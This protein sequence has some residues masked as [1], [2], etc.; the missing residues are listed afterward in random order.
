MVKLYPVAIRSFISGW[1]SLLLIIGLPVTLQAQVPQVDPPPAY[2]VTAYTQGAAGAGSF[3]YDIATSPGATGY[4]HVYKYLSDFT[5]T[6][7]NGVEYTEGQ[8][9]GSSVFV[10]YSDDVPTGNFYGS[11]SNPTYVKIYAYNGNGGSRIYSSTALTFTIFTLPSVLATQPSGQGTGLVFS[12]ISTSGFSYNFAAA[13]GTTLPDGYLHLR[14]EGSAPA[15]VPI[16]GYEIDVANIQQ[17]ADGTIVEY[18]DNIPSGFV[19][20]AKA[21]TTYHYRIYSYKG[22]GTSRNYN[23]TSPLSGQVTTTTASI[24]ST[25]QPSAI[26]FSSI[27][28]TGFTH[29][30]T[31]A[32][33]PP[34]GY[35]G[36]TRTGA[37]P[38]GVPVDGTSYEV[39]SVLGDGTVSFVG[40]QL[41]G[42][43]SG[44][45]ASTTYH[46]DVFSYDNIGIKAEYYNNRNFASEPV[47]TANVGEIDFDFGTGSP[48]ASVNVDNFSARYSFQIRPTVSG[49]YT[50]ETISDDGVVLFVNGAKVIDKWLQQGVT[51][52]TGVI[53][54]TANTTYDVVL[55][56]FEL[57]SAASVRLNWTPPGGTKELVR[58]MLGPSTNYLT[59]A[60]LQNSVTTTSSLATEPTAQ[61]TALT[62][63]SVTN[64][65]FT[66]S[67][68]AAAGSPAG[69]IAVR[70]SGATA[71][72]TDPVDGTAYTV[73]AALGNG[74]V[75]FVGSAVTFNQT[76]LTAST[77]YN[78]K[79][80]SY[81]GSGTT[82][83]YRQTTPLT[84]NTTTA[85]SLATE[86]TSQPTVFTTTSITSSSF[87]VS[88]T[89]A[90]GSPAGY[91]AVRTSG[92]TAP[93]TD[94]VDGTAYTVDTALG[95]GT[96]AFVGS[97]VTF[98]QTGLTASTQYNYKIY[99]YNGSGTTI[100]YRQT[101]PLTGNTTTASSLAT[102]PASQPTVF[103]TTSITSSSFTVSYTAATGTP[104]GY[105]AVRKSGSASTT[106][107]ADGTAYTVGATLGDGIIAYVGTA[108]T[109]NEAELAASTQYFYKIYT[110]NGTGTATNYLQTNP[111]QGNVTT[112]A[113]PPATENL[114]FK[115]VTTSVTDD[116]K[117]IR[118]ASTQTAYA[119]G[120]DGA[121]I[122]S[123]D[124]GSTWA[125]LTVPAGAATATL[126]NVFF[127]SLNTGYIVGD[128]GLII[129]TSNGGSTWTTLSSGITNDLYDI[130]FPTPNIGYMVGAAGTIIKTIDAGATWLPLSSGVTGNYL[131]SVVFLDALIGLAAGPNGIIRTTDGGTTWNSVANQSIEW[132]SF[133][134]STVGYG[135]GDG[136]VIV[137]TLNAGLTWTPL[138][139]NTSENLWGAYFTS[140]N[141]GFAVGE[142]GTVI[143]TANG[144]STWINTTTDFS[145]ENL[146]AVHF[147]TNERGIT[148][149]NFGT[150]LITEAELPPISI[151]ASNFKN[152]IPAAGNTTVSI[153]IPISDVARVDAVNAYVFAI[154]D[155]ANNI[156][157]NGEIVPAVLSSNTYTATIQDTGDDPIGY[158]YFFEIAY[159]GFNRYTSSDEGYAYL[160]YENTNTLK[161]PSLKAGST[162]NDYQ[163]ISVPL[164]LTN[165]QVGAVFDEFG[166][167]DNK[168][169]RMFTYQSGNITPLSINGSITPGKGYWLITKTATTIDV[170]PGKTVAA[171][172]ES[173][174]SLSL[175]AGWNLIGNP[176]NFG[177]T[178]NAGTDLRELKQ[179]SNG[180]YST[181]STMQPFV[182]YFVFANTA[183]NYPI[184]VTGAFIGGRTRTNRFDQTETSWELPI[185]LQR[186]DLKNELGG[187]G[188]HQ[189]ADAGFDAFDEPALPIP[190]MQNM[191][192]MIFHR[193]DLPYT[194]NKEV[195]PANQNYTWNFTIDQPEGN[196]V[197]EMQ[198]DP[199]LLTELKNKLYLYDE[200]KLEV[201]DMMQKSMHYTMANS[202]ITILYGD[203]F[204]I[205]NALAVKDARIAQPYPNPASESMQIPVVLPEAGLVSLH[206]HDSYGRSIYE[207]EQFYD[208]GN[209]RISI[210]NLNEVPSG[211]Y[212]VTAKILSGANSH[213]KTFK[214]VINQ[215]NK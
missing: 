86:P 155:I 200:A 37:S 3:S 140:T 101:T 186:G 154:R 162:V 190:T 136:G 109:F 143:K 66:V 50:F 28:P 26:T 10:K 15:Y 54:L 22:L 64:S 204:Y 198:W 119:V 176:Y 96:V 97:A 125:P 80:Y 135:V 106:D 9:L 24:Q 56:Y 100:N 133:P 78:Y 180:T 27:G 207:S 192:A 165:A 213:R 153:T 166:A 206:M 132:L 112:L 12:D 23:T 141:I 203:E 39:N 44:L 157:T 152:E 63:S 45:T 69:Y 127:T 83:N 208:Q 91:I 82:I 53:S 107:P 121:A 76:G 145:S 65:S 51:A 47:A 210:Q 164:V 21:G 214:I 185:T 59:T 31:A 43:R 2:T 191:F 138:T 17:L 89:A 35:I 11:V 84:G 169:W 33:G 42:S 174:F 70:T 196:D 52:H 124:A 55:L 139:S 193:P 61:P 67:Y 172:G 160:K 34:D 179:F 57:G 74:T 158:Y 117:A 60:P 46:Y 90:T 88:Y 131:N 177:V 18:T 62:F 41:T 85:S 105:I 146:Y 120:T 29:T 32:A 123:T 6:P 161:L 134:S 75:A 189:E 19:N 40:P 8:S 108:I 93:N 20:N 150:I 175:V 202:T 195:V 115:S 171:N 1:F 48:S 58:P 72:N 215:N 16:D 184:P 30:L 212:F 122:K 98:N 170:G 205:K 151:S 38:T 110:Y 209:H 163:I 7:T 92:A 4:L 13:S 87:T 14:K 5:F 126:W 111:L 68:V 114:A 99:S 128:A 173:P 129:K 79:I 49:S 181:S 118:F 95:N 137:K 197:V 182:G 194:L 156:F 211:I 130:A 102:E 183:G 188:M 167:V 147:G 144:G 113:P 199:M 142:N 104:T 81:N 25:A 187:I 77:Q 94:P 201:V 36:L 73:G 178:W 116:L 148:V 168:Q 159:D 103:S 71:P 149:G